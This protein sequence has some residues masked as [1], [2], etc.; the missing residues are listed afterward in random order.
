MMLNHEQ[1]LW[2]PQ[3]IINSWLNIMLMLNAAP[4]GLKERYSQDRSL[5]CVGDHQLLLSASA[6]ALSASFPVF[7]SVT[8]SPSL[9]F[10]FTV[11]PFHSF[12]FL[13]LQLFSVVTQLFS[14]TPCY[15]LCSEY[16]AI[17]FQFHLDS[18]RIYFP[19]FIPAALPLRHSIHAFT[20]NRQ[21]T[22]R[23]NPISLLSVLY[24]E[25]DIQFL[26][27][28]VFQEDLVFR[29]QRANSLLPPLLPE[30]KKKNG[31]NQY[32]TLNSSG[33]AVINCG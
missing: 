28:L 15:L 13:F 12:L 22:Q 29:G 32:I 6:S 2:V 16:T 23:R 1:N 24:R 26:L 14:C 9:T 31:T 18:L 30:K 3:Q 10:S 5:M 21:T 17:R 25:C 7:V 20:N 11:W 27:G 19:S 4:F 33:N 8:L